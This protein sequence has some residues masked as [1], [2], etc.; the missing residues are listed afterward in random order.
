M[1]RTCQKDKLLTFCEVRPT[2]N[3]I[4][5][6]TEDGDQNLKLP[7]LERTWKKD[8]FLTSCEVRSSQMDVQFEAK[9]QVTKVMLPG[10]ERT[11]QKDKILTFCEVRSAPSM[12]K[13]M[14]IGKLAK[15]EKVS[16]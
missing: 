6:G 3:G 11:C 5:I 2:Q 12:S 15:E 1:E 4:Q 14:Q 8:K 9:C 16:T 7:G 10:M 13:S